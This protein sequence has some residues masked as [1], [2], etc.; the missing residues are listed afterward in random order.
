LASVLTDI[1]RTD[2][3]YIGEP[4]VR[5]NWPLQAKPTHMTTT[6]TRRSD[7]IDWLNDAYAMER[8]LEV[9][10]R[11]QAENEGAHHAVRER[12]RI[13]LDET[14]VHAERVAQCLEM[15]EATPSTIKSVTGQAMEFAKGMM[16]KMA[17]DERVKD[18]LC[19]YSA[20][21]FEVACYKA[22]IAGASVAG[23]EE[24]VPL[25]EKNLKEDQAMASWLDA[26]VNA[27]VRDYLFDAS[28]AT[29]AA[30]TA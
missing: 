15:L 19:A 11:K 4:V 26:N 18:F 13:H 22:L 10:L 27:V 14:E 25:L 21:Y 2:F 5:T 16:S 6:N 20:E 12:A 1:G 8:S 7:V 17:S 29:T 3:D 23:A 28:R 9:M 24:I 30:S